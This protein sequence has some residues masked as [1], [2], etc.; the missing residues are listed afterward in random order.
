MLSSAQ[1]ST[2]HEIVAVFSRESELTHAIEDFQLQGFDHAEISVLPHRSEVIRSLGR[3][4]LTVLELEDDPYVP[5]THCVDHGSY[6]VAQG[7]LIAA[8]LYLFAC[9]AA[10]GLAGMGAP[11]SAILL[12][13]L[14]GA[15]LG[16]AAGMLAMLRMRRAHNE[17]IQHQ[18][19]HGGLL[20]WV[21]T[22]DQAHAD[23]A[24]RILARHFAHDVHLHPAAA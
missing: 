4:P 17:H 20:L 21:R 7:A 10:A 22:A 13:T 19:D 11:L 12:G 8:P 1:Q 3:E 16:A 9:G 2:S 15:L 5:R 18:L 23:T 24:Q 6:A 14:A